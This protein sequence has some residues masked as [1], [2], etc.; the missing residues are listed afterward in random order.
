MNIYFRFLALMF[1][2]LFF[3]VLSFS[4]L[5]E[6]VTN[7]ND[8]GPGSLRQA[9]ADVDPFGEVRLDASIDGMTIALT[10][11]ELVIDKQISLFGTDA[12]GAVIDGSATA[13]PNVIRIA[14]STG[15]VFIGT[16]NITGHSI[17]QTALSV[18]SDVLVSTTNFRTF[19]SARGVEV[20]ANARSDNFSSLFQNHDEGVNVLGASGNMTGGIFS[21]NE[22]LIR[23]NNIGVLALGGLDMS[24]DG[25]NASVSESTLSGNMVGMSARG[26]GADS[27]QGGNVS[28]R[29]SI[30]IN[31]ISALASFSGLQETTLGGNIDAL[32]ITITGSMDN[33]VFVEGGTT[34]M[35]LGGTANINFS[36]INQN[37]NDGLEVDPPA[38]GNNAVINIKNS[39]VSENGTDCTAVAGEI[40]ATGLNFDTD[41]TC[42]ALDVDF[43]TAA[44]AAI[45]LGPLQNN[46]GMTD[47]FDLLIPSAAIDAAPDCTEIDATTVD[48]DQ[49][50]FPRPFGASCD[51]GA[52]EQ[53]PTGML[54]I[55]KLSIPP[56]ETGF[57]FGGDGF[58]LGCEFNIIF[59]MDDGET[60]SCIIPPAVV[61]IT[62]ILTF[63]AGVN[64]VCSENPIN[65]TF[66]SITLDIAAGDDVTCTLTNDTRPFILN[67]I[68]PALASNLNIIDVI[69]A[70]ASG[71]VAFLWGFLPGS[72]IIG[73]PT[74]NG[75]E[76]DIA[77]P[78]ILSIV[79]AF[80]NGVAEYIFWIPLIGDFE[81]PILTQAVDIDTCRKSEVLLNIIR[82]E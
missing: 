17:T 74:C 36:T 38:N 69:D 67:P 27:A 82:K 63:N 12:P 31:N 66:D 23:N 35:A 68:F 28:S 62:D 77:N 2:L 70:T 49:R 26:G 19:A 52:V 76:I 40:V 21:C 61:T 79:N 20:R 50:L 72:T 11:G 1:F 65:Q 73:G 58:P 78:Q 47:T 3:P 45:N 15:S 25:G 59:S 5:L 55:N 54:T 13:D 80:P 29:H 37:T 7:N 22:C 60:L 6:T 8:S 44:P 24:A 18:G 46:G 33:G 75:L 48:F 30:F 64:F 4:A 51:L 57:T 53:Q 43:S 42:N 16:I 71:P 14:D 39:I 56:G 81:L 32:N 34:D 10:S 41:G 9:L